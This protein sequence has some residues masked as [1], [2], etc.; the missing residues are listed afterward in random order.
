MF[1]VL[2]DVL[3]MVWPA[4]IALTVFCIWLLTEAVIFVIQAVIN[5]KKKLTQKNLAGVI[6]G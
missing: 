6:Y 5:Y 2:I 3:C 4:A 1:D